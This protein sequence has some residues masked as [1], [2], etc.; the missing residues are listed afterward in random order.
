[1]PQH[2]QQFM[3]FMLFNHEPIQP[4]SLVKEEHMAQIT[5][6]EM[7]VRNGK[8]LVTPPTVSAQNDRVIVTDSNGALVGSEVTGT[9]L[10]QL[11]GQ[12]YIDEDGDLC[13][14]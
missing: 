8:A 1:M 11:M 5:G 4:N 9:K 14:L 6:T 10:A 13:Q 12:F 7:I 3:L 2:L